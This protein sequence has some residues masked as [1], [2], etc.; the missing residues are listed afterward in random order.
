MGK[1]H[2]REGRRSARSVENNKRIRLKGMGTNSLR[3]EKSRRR[4]KCLERGDEG[5]E[6]EKERS[7]RVV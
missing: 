5:K 7:G 4:G 6:E 1:D 2:G 3:K